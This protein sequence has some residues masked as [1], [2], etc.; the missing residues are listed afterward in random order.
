MTK[1][2]IEQC[3]KR[4]LLH[5][6]QKMMFRRAVFEFINNNFVNTCL[7]HSVHTQPMCKKQPSHLTKHLETKCFA[8]YVIHCFKSLIVD[9]LRKT[10]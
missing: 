10:G 6:C 5:F 1:M 8:F 3:S 4:V 7:R 2:S 9:F